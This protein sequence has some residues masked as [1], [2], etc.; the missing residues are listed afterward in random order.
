[1]KMSE[2]VCVIRRCG[3]RLLCVGESELDT[4][5]RAS[6]KYSR[7]TQLPASATAVAV[8]YCTQMTELLLKRSPLLELWPSHPT[9]ER[10]GHTAAFLTPFRSFGN[11]GQ[12][13][14]LWLYGSV[15]L[16]EY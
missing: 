11:Y 4:L 12:H 15:V 6:Y 3:V 8:A 16:L 1:M 14:F 10:M 9:F 7:W 13:L 5:Q 2:D